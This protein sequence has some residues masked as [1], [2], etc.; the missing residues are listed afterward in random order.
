MVDD[1]VTLRDDAD[2]GDRP[3]VWWAAGARPGSQPVWR[4]MAAGIPDEHVAR[5]LT[6]FT[7]IADLLLV[8]PGRWI[9]TTRSQSPPSGF[10]GRAINAAKNAVLGDIAPGANGWTSVALEDRVEWW[11]DRISNLAAIA[12]AAPSAGGF[13]ASRLNTQDLLGAAGAGLTV[14][15]VAQEYGLVEPNSW[16]PIVGQV[17]FHRQPGAVA[18]GV[19]PSGLEVPQIKRPTSRDEAM[20]LLRQMSDSLKNIDSLLDERP[21][22]GFIARGISKVPAVGVAGGYLAERKAMRRAADQ[23]E[24]LLNR[25]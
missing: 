10:A 2:T 14:C 13:L 8:E 16:V 6:G 25:R 9:D 15:A 11:V 23:A 3:A 17:V 1:V 7:R 4:H 20:A 18:N 24:Q 19:T 21:K 12:A 22:G 5:T